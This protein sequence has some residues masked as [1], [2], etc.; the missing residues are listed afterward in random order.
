MLNKSDEPIDIQTSDE[1]NVS[2]PVIHVH[3]GW[4][5]RDVLLNNIFSGTSALM[6]TIAIG[7][8]LWQVF[9]R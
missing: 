2:A 7:T 6:G 5:R 8:V 9:F 4:S 1:V 3:G